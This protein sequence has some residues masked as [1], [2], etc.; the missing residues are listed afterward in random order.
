MRQLERGGME[1]IP[2]ERQ[3]GGHAGGSPFIRLRTQFGGRSIE[4]VTDNG[5]PDRSHVDAN[6]VG[7]SGLDREFDQSK[8]A[9]RSID[10]SLHEVMGYRLAA[11]EAPGGHAGAFLR[12]AADGA[13]N[14]AAILFG[15]A[16]DERKIGFVHFAAAELLRQPAMRFVVLRDHHQAAGG[17]IE[18]MDNP[19]PQLAAD[20]GEGSE[21]MQQGIDQGSAIARV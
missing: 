5:M 20:R 13:L 4:R 7:A 1:E 11:S 10:L 17:A 14:G 3:S 9:I 18:A 12:V 21:M 19:G 8:L 15:P 2:V 6:L 16:V